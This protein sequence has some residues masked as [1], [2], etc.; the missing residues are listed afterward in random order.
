MELSQRHS[1]KQEVKELLSCRR[2][3]DIKPRRADSVQPIP[4]QDAAGPS[5]HAVIFV[6][7]EL[8]NHSV[9]DGAFGGMI[10]QITLKCANCS[11]I[12]TDA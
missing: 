11:R 3:V 5:T 9:P 1:T 6:L 12:Q 10:L 7:S 2:G 4:Q 8:F